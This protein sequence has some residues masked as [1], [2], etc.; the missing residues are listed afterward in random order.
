MFRVKS[1]ETFHLPG[2]A[3]SGDRMSPPG[4]LANT[5]MPNQ[6]P[7]PVLCNYVLGIAA[8]LHF[9]LETTGEVG[10]ASWGKRKRKG[11]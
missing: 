4:L 5:L 6:R 7:S 3:F 2:L 10:K 1:C 8:T 11:V 9:L